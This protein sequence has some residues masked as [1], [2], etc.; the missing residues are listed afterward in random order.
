M[1]VELE[2]YLREAGES[3]RRLGE[4]RGMMLEEGGGGG[5]V[6]EG[7]RGVEWEWW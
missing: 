1:A 4:M 5:E 2:S 3:G 6:R 7:R